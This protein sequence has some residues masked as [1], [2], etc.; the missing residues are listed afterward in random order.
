MLNYIHVT[1]NHFLI[2]SDYQLGNI[3]LFK[4]VC[5]CRLLSINCVPG[6]GGDNKYSEGTGRLGEGQ[7]RSMGLTDTNYYT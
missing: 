7:I 4:T 2:I 6:S 5:I 1:K 3:F